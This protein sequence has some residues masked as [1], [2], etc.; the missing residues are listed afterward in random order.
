MNPCE[1]KILR[2]RLL[3]KFVL[4]EDG[5]SSTVEVK[6]KKKR[7]KAK[8]TVVSDAVTNEDVHVKTVKENLSDVERQNLEFKPP[9]RV[10][11]LVIGE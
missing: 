2:Q 10:V 7:R 6:N 5:S 4:W 1:S 11:K 8:R 3:E 9:Q